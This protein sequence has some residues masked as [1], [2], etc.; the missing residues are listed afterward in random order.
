[1]PYSLVI[2]SGPRAGLR[3]PLPNH[4]SVTLGRAADVDLLL[5][6]EDRFLSRHHARVEVQPDGVYLH[7]LAGRKTTSVNGMPV[8]WARLAPGNVVRLGN[9]LLRLVYDGSDRPMPTE[10]ADDV[11]IYEVADASQYHQP[12]LVISPASSLT[13]PRGIRALP[14]DAKAEEVLSC[15]SCG[16][17]GLPAPSPDLWDAGWLCPSCRDEKRKFFPDLPDRVGR[18][19]VLGKLQQGGMGLL[20]EAVSDDGVHVVI[21]MLRAGGVAK[22]A[23]DRFLREQRIAAAL[24]HPNIVRCYEVG[25]HDEH[26]YIV[27]EY[28]SGGS[29]LD[30]AGHEQPVQDVLWLGADLF[31]ALGYAHDL[32]IVHRDVSPANV[33]L[34]GRDLRAGVRAKLADFG[35][36]KSRIDLSAMDITLAGEAGGST[37]TMGPEQ[38]RNFIQVAPSADIYSAAAT[39]FWMLTRDT[40]LVLPCPLQDAPM[41]V[42]KEAIINP[43][44]RS[45]AH[46]RPG[47]PRPVVELIDSLVA[48]HPTARERLSAKQIAVTLGELAERVARAQ[49]AM[50][51]DPPDSS[52]RSTRR[53]DVPPDRF[54]VALSTLEF[55]VNTL[56]RHVEMAA[57]DVRSAIESQDPERIERALARHQRLREDV[58][59]SVA[60]WEELVNLS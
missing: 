13:P 18:F 39:V 41:H 38:V 9:T 52:K 40:P 22:K 31:R 51:P 3:L 27:S 36:A 11:S 59:A 47:V 5:P 28:V 25:T 42:R 17:T 49:I 2:S 1:M 37:L 4:Q 33:L 7:D 45:L 19:Q 21:K 24:R 23:M 57:A 12:Q 54:S 35:L 44:R 43:A 26:P 50:A 56:D 8:R 29:A 58:D 48:H 55:F 53:I 30:L 60:R 20:L 46:V 6:Q 14:G 10:G 34:T 16:A 32:G 15:D